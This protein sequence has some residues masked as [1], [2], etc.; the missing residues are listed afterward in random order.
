MSPRLRAGL[1]VLPLA[2]GG[3]SLWDEWFGIDKPPLPGT[4]IA[5]ATGASGLEIAPSG[6]PKVTI[7][8]AADVP[9]SPQS[10][11]TPAHVLENPALGA[12]VARVWSSSIGAGGGYRSRLTAP[13]LV[14]A[15]R[16]FTM[17]SDGVVTAFDAASGSQAWSRVTEDDEDRSTNVGGGIA[18]DDGTVY[19]ATG[20][21]EVLAIDA[22]SGT[23]KWRARLPAGARGAPTVA[24]GKLFIPLID[25]QFVAVSTADGS[26][27]W[28]YQASSTHP[29]ILGAPAPAFADGLLLVGSPAGD[30]VALYP[31]SGAVI[32]ADSLAA[33][34]GRGSLADVASI[35]GR[36]LIKSGRAYAVSLGQ[37]L[38]AFDARN[39]RRLWER[40]V[41]SSESPWLAGD[42]LYVTTADNRV[43][44]LSVIDGQ[45]AWVTQL[46]SY[47]NMEKKK[48][49]ISWL[50]PVLAGGRLRIAGT[51]G[52]MLDLSP[53]TGQILATTPLSGPAAITPVVAG[54]TLYIVTNDGT[55]TAFR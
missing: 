3:C 19:A 15:G 35:S 25:S 24:A 44:A 7:P 29:V 31:P 43:A 23:I 40:A 27:S 8:P 20:R 48:D 52:T 18:F 11:G 41:S 26:K 1:I 53:T 32:W 16:V 12:Q 51:N 36:I 39:G 14:A 45:V 47:E 9:A 54:G 30:I 13:P 2:L 17:D 33:G 55:L 34:R 28:S 42:T 4:R 21:A 50:G 22:A 38:A 37:Q 6:G 46:D 5:L 10:G 49:P